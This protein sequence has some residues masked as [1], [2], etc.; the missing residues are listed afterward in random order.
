MLTHLRSLRS[1]LVCALLALLPV[2]AAAATPKYT[3]VEPA[4]RN[5][6]Y[7]MDHGA[8]LLLDVYRPT[9]PN[10]LALIFVMG[11]GFTAEGEYGDIPLKQL[12]RHL[13]DVGI[14][15]PLFGGTGH[16]FDPALAAGFTV[17]SLNHR[18]A[19]A[20]TWKTQIR[21]C[22]RAVQWVRFHAKTYGIN[23]ARIGG[24]GHS[25][26]ATMVTFLG[27]ADDLADPKAH[28]PINRE[29]TRLQAVVTLSGLHDLL[30]YREERPA[31]AA[32]VAAF[33]GRTIMYQPPGHPIFADHRAASTV[34]HVTQDDAPMLIY[35]GDADPAVDSRQSE[36]LA[37]ALKAAGVAH[38]LHL[39]PGADHGQLAKPMTPTPVDH[40]ATWLL[41]RLK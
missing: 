16:A 7:G 12:N 1:I 25:S 13:V 6:V 27:V 35:H 30:A 14:F 40:A 15:A 22:Q 33:V 21:D 23:P 20:H 10:G 9:R 39:L 3:F 19:P 37:R 11:T 2:A 26:G 31:G 18:L 36:A 4:E 34:S 41:A 8:A 38:E 28:D 17:F 29:S 5:V 24:L 32:I